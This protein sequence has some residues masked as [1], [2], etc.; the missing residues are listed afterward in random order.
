MVSPEP[1]S[2]RP[3]E[4]PGVQHAACESEEFEATDPLQHIPDTAILLVP[5][6]QVVV[7]KHRHARK[8][9]CGDALPTSAHAERQAS[10]DCQIDDDHEVTQ[11][12]IAEEYLQGHHASNPGTS[13]CCPEEG[14]DHLPS[15][16]AGALAKNGRVRHIGFGKG[17]AHRVDRR[18][19]REPP[20]PGS[21]TARVDGQ[22]IELHG[23]QRSSLETALEEL[24]HACRVRHLA[25]LVC[26]HHLQREHQL[27]EA[28]K[29]ADRQ[30]AEPAQVLE[31]RIVGGQQ[32]HEGANDKDG[33]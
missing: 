3:V 28:Q 7:H 21:P 24:G 23:R 5:I 8:E 26:L 31:R 33:E 10:A 25:G 14:Q 20:P 18:K 17:L 1:R 2:Q 4:L 9:H 6:I 30:P 12:P 32:G 27:E 16:G 19:D 13:F 11:M 22:L 29:H 15:R